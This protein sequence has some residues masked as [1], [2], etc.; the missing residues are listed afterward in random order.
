MFRIDKR[1]RDKIV[2]IGSAPFHVIVTVKPAIALG[3]G[4]RTMIL[5]FGEGDV[6][7]NGPGSAVL[8]EPDDAIDSWFRLI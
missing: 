7:A 5:S 4:V 8:T 3:I 6:A 2:L 1:R